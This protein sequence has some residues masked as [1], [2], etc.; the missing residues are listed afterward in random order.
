MFAVPLLVYGLP[1][2]PR[3]AV[4]IS[5]AA[6]GMTSL[7]GFYGRWKTG[8]VEVATGLMFAVAGMTGAPVGS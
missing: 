4:G 8:Q 7:V 6:V 3:Q 1:I 2:D 5:L